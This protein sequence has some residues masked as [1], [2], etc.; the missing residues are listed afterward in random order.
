MKYAKHAVALLITAACLYLAFHDIDLHE[1]LRVFDPGRIHWLPMIGFMSICLAVMWIRAWRWKYFYLKEHRATIWGLTVAN[2]I[3]FMVN[4]I[5]PL[6]L[7][8]LVRALIAVR[9]TASPLSYTIGVLFIERLL[10]TLCLIFCLILG[11]SFS[12]GMPEAAYLAGQL[13]TAAFFGAV[14]ILY[15]LRGKPQ[16]LMKVVL[17]FSRK[18]L[19]ERLVPRAERFLHLFTDGLRILQDGKAMLKIL[20][21]SLF[22]WWLIV[23]SYHLAFDAFSIGPLPWTAPYL[24]LGMV[25]LGVA[26]PSSPAYVGPVH[27]AIVFSLV[28]YG[29]DQPLAQGFAV[30]MHLLM[31]GPITLVGLAMMWREGLSLSTIRQRAEKTGAEKTALA[32]EP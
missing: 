18:L 28:A 16:L 31:F 25:G 15:L 8:E 6:R 17:P 10:D 14:F 23:Y 11:L 30:I 20:A 27:A 26:V 12:S 9:K 2:L 5:L 21:L 22:H 4:N 3:G 7:G 24:T 29:I 13:T 32:T 1:A 19:P